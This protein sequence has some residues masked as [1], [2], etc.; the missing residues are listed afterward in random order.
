METILQMKI[1]LYYVSY[2]CYDTFQPEAYGLGE[3]S[4]GKC[5]TSFQENFSS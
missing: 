4:F 2:L 1:V 5:I 3:E